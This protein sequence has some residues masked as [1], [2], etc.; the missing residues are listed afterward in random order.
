[1]ASMNQPYL[2]YLK[3]DKMSNCSLGFGLACNQLQGK[4]LRDRKTSE[5]KDLFCHDNTMR[6]GWDI[7]LPASQSLTMLS[8]WQDCDEVSFALTQ[9]TYWMSEDFELVS[10]LVTL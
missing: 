4:Y 5:L 2:E 8:L 9:Q 3:V 7:M 10:R 1:M 6:Y